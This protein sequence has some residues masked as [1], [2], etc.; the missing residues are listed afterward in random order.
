MM[1]VAA[2]QVY[3]YVMKEAKQCK[4]KCDYAS[5]KLYLQ[6]SDSWAEIYLL[7]T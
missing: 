7:M 5:I 6:T 1:R 2:T 3:D 4:W